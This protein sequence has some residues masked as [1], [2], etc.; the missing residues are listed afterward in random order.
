[1]FPCHFP[2]T[3]QKDDKMA[4]LVTAPAHTV[5]PC[6]A[7]PEAPR[8]EETEI[9]IQGDGWEK[10]IMAKYLPRLQT[11]SLLVSK[12]R[13]KKHTGYWIAVAMAAY[14]LSPSFPPFRHGRKQPVQG[15]SFWWHKS[16]HTKDQCL[17]FSHHMK[18]HGL[19]QTAKYNRKK[20]TQQSDFNH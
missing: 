13:W 14:S 15:S 8:L 2:G 20:T 9:S 1:M 4:A 18:K 7:L 6:S 17:V 19:T 5:L 3:R 12:Q 10:I 16:H 11:Y